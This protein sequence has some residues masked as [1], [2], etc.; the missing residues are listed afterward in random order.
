MRKNTCF[1]K[2]PKLSKICNLVQMLR[3]IWKKDEILMRHRILQI[4]TSVTLREQQKKMR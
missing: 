2:R 1:I 3:F 4:K